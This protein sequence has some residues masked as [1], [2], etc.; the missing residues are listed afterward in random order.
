MKFKIPKPLTLEHEE[1]HA[2]LVKAI[3][4]Q[5]ENSDSG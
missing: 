4:L 5:E 1:L 3:I 2:E